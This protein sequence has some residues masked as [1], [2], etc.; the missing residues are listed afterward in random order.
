MSILCII[1]T[2]IYIIQNNSV[3]ELNNVTLRNIIKMT[4]NEIDKIGI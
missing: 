4:Y 3:F 2:S 1:W